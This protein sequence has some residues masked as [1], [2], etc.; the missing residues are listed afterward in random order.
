MS[1]AAKGTLTFFQTLAWEPLE[2]ICWLQSDAWIGMPCIPTSTPDSLFEMRG[3]KVMFTFNLVSRFTSYCNFC[4]ISLDFWQSIAAVVAALYKCH[5][6]LN[7]QNNMY[8]AWSQAWCIDR[9]TEKVCRYRFNS[10]ERPDGS[11]TRRFSRS[12]GL[13]EC[14]S[15]R[16][17]S[18][19]AMSQT[20]LARMLVY[21]KYLI[22]CW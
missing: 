2:H 4:A 7:W 8:I 19:S 1:F 17:L 9:R 15:C 16:C 22:V 14:S 21:S 11:T 12:D 6:I 10:G 18:A 5:L 3:H 20:S 13:M